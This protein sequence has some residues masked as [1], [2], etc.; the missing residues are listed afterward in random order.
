LIPLPLKNWTP[1]FPHEN[2]DSPGLKIKMPGLGP[3][4]LDPG[5]KNPREGI[6]ERWPG[7]IRTCDLAYSGSNPAEY[8]QMRPWPSL[9]SKL[10]I[11][12]YLNPFY[13]FLHKSVNMRLSIVP[14]FMELWFR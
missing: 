10:W 5:R 9:S 1:W 14:Q 2:N 11:V 12:I 6:Y 13:C 7:R 3:P 8:C 4:K